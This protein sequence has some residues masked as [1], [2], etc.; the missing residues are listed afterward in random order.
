LICDETAKLKPGTRARALPAFFLKAMKDPFSHARLAGVKA[1]QAC[2]SY[3]D[4]PTLAT[5]FMPALSCLA[6]DN[7]SR[8]RE[9]A[10]D[11]IEVCV[12]S[13]KKWQPAV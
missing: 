2:I 6:A 12:L 13:S 7:S 9:A 5:K 3:F 1:T 4:A 8:V 11:C 10:L